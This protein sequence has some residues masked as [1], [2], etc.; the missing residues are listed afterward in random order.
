MPKCP[1]APEPLPS[2]WVMDSP[3]LF[4]GAR[5]PPTPPGNPPPPGGPPGAPPRTPLPPPPPTLRPT[6]SCRGGGVGLQNRGVA[7][8]PPCP[9]RM[10]GGGGGEVD[11]VRVV[12]GWA[13]GALAPQP[14]AP[15]C[16][17]PAAAPTPRLSLSD[18]PRKSQSAPRHLHPAL[19]M[20]RHRRPRH[21]P[22][23]VPSG[24]RG[25]P[26]GDV[27]HDWHHRNVVIPGPMRA[28]Y[29]L[30]CRRCW[31]CTTAR[32]Q[33]PSNAT[34]GASAEVAAA[35]HILC[36]PQVHTPAHTSQCW[37]WQTPAWTRA[38]HRDAPGQRHGQQPRLRDGRPPE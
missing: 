9:P 24:V 11:A 20:R 14:P 6:V 15:R 10:G 26:C 38:V 27:H 19:P 2:V 16:L 30:P 31:G 33:T 13:G 18:V 5:H 28:K 1:Q 22:L 12:V 35:P 8:P 21:V 37:G 32:G 34:G 23:H 29:A 7:H 36:I 3:T 25:R 17:T 4:G